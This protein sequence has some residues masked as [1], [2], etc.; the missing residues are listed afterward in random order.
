MY[1][2]YQFSVPTNTLVDVLR[3]IGVCV[4]VCVHAERLSDCIPISPICQL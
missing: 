1:M 3:G 2:A 4:C